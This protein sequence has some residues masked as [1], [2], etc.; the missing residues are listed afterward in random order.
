A[1]ATTNAI[2]WTQ[3]EQ[4]QITQPPAAAAS[5]GT[6]PQSPPDVD[7]S[8]FDYATTHRGRSN[9]YPPYGLGVLAQHL[10]DHNIQVQ[11]CNLNHAILKTC[12]NSK[13]SSQFDF[14]S[15]WRNKLSRDFHD[16]QP[17]LIG[18]TC[19]FS[20]THKSF[21][22]VCKEVK[23][24]S[25]DWRKDNTTVPL[26]IGGVHVTHDVEKMIAEI[27]EA[28]FIFLNEAE[29]AFLNFI[30]VVNHKKPEND[31]GQLIIKTPEETFR[32]EQMVLPIENQMNILPAYE[33]MEL[34]E[35]SKV[36]TLGSWYGFKES[37]I[38]IATVL[39]NRGCRAACTFCNVRNFNGI[40]VRH[41]SVE[42]VLD[43]LTLLHEK[44]GIGHFIWL[45]DDLLHDEKRSLELFN[46]MVKRNLPLT[47]DATN[48]L[49]AH[50]CC[51]EELMAAAAES[52]CIGIHIGVESG[53][54]EILKQIKKPG[55]VDTFL[56]AA[57]VLQKFEQIN[58]RILL[59]IG[60]PGET[61][62]MIL[63]TIRLAENMGMDWSNI[64]ILQP[65]KSTPIYDSMVEQGMIDQEGTLKTS[66]NKIS[67]YNLG[68]YSRQRAIER[69]AISHTQNFVEILGDMDLDTVPAPSQLDD[70]WFL[71][72]YRINFSKLFSETRPVKLD[73]QYRWLKYIHTLTAPD[74]AI[75]M[76]FYGYLQKQVLGHICPELVS[77][78]EKRLN[79]SSYW[80]ERFSFLGLS[81]DHLKRETFP[82]TKESSPVG[83]DVETVVH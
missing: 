27:P 8:L 75:V 45:D 50:S 24:L 67:P 1:L 72:N 58:T 44:Y 17:D 81:S 15:T 21:A 60:F 2:N 5:L 41:R 23:G 20:V 14:E 59:M 54:P 51:N 4:D 16:F 9:N 47:W 82:F 10:L 68:P 52:G 53:N 73:Q 37:G 77:K 40:G 61:L 12:L 39:S 28:E 64:A 34:D 65:W 33:L 49:I 66:E 76:Y 19:L 74:N 80:N 30:D 35:Y 31:L 3:K 11:I 57:E 70:I 83:W 42:S 26:A 29:I 18:V 79:E 6:P 56:K 36:G 25:A 71:M 32:F 22:S 63:D 78:L 43:E 62:R 48:G 13:S 38:S 7:V 69:G 55:T 46:Q